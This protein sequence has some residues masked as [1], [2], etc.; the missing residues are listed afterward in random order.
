MGPTPLFVDCDNT[1]GLPGAEIDD[2]LTILYLLDQ[3]TVRIVGISAT[4]GNADV[5]TVTRQTSAL[6]EALGLD[7]AVARGAQPEAAPAT[8][9]ATGPGA[10]EPGDAARALVAAS[11]E[12]SGRLVVL[13]LGALTN[14]AAASALD[15]GFFGRLA[16]ILVMGGYLGP[17]RFPRREVAE[18]NFSADPVAA[19][20]VLN[21]PCP[22]TIMSAQLC[23]AARFGRRH[24]LL[25][26]R[27]PRWLRRTV[28]AW[29][30]AF[31]GATGARGFYLWDLV[32]AVA[33]CEADRIP[34]RLV[35]LTSSGADLDTG[36]L[37]L[38]RLET[39]VAAGRDDAHLA[40]EPGV[41]SV[42][43]RI[44]RRR[45]FVADCAASWARAARTRVPRGGMLRGANTV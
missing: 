4:H 26:N 2:G 25:Y 27:G 7:L 10:G 21:A 11:R 19:H 39:M 41:V 18:L 14:I 22:V 28:R 8:T 38:E 43:D 32:P 16:G 9:A 29:Y 31:S 45:R 33:A 15:P 13:G 40:C 5:D 12:H 3:P 36:R 23:L 1:M 44:L 35:R 30:R 42:P 24:L 37:R 6:V 20:T 17:L 34:S